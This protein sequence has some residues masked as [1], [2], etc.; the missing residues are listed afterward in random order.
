MHDNMPISIGFYHLT[1]LPHAPYQKLPMPMPPQIKACQQ[2]LELRSTDPDRLARHFAWEE[3]AIAPLQPLAP[4]AR[5]CFMMPNLVMSLI[6]R[7][8]PALKAVPW[9]ASCRIWFAR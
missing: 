6:N 1:D 4:Q 8:R 2:L 3:E 7:T 9:G 5:D